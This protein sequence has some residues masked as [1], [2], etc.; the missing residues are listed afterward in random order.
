MTRRQESDA[1]RLSRRQALRI[2]GGLSATAALAACG[3]TPTANPTAGG[4]ATV[5]PATVAA[6]SLA[7]TASIGAASTAP[8]AAGV[9]AT[10]TRGA[11]SATA[12]AASTAITLPPPGA[13]FPTG[14][15][16]VKVTVQGPGPRS[17]F[18][19]EFFAAYK[20]ARPN[21]T[22][23]FDE[24]PAE[25]LNQ[26]VSLSIQNNNAPDI[27][28]LP[29]VVTGGQA[30]QQGWV[31][32][33]DDVIPNFAALK[34]T[35]PSGVLAEGITVFGGKVYTLPL[36]SNQR[37]ETLVIYNPDL[38]QRAGYDPA[39]TPFTWDTFRAACQKITQQGA[40]KY[41]GLILGGKAPD[42]NTDAFVINLAQMAGAA[43]GLIDWRTGLYNYASDQFLA[44]TELLLAISKD[45]SILPGSLSLVQ[46]D[47]TTRLA[48]GGAAMTL[49]GPWAPTRWAEKFNY[50]VASQPVPN[51]GTPLPITYAPGGANLHWLSAKSRNAAIVGDIFGYWSSAPGQTAF[52]GIVGSALQAVLPEARRVAGSDPL[53]QTMSSLF[54]RQ[55]RLAPDPRVRNPDAGQVFVEQRAVRPDLGE[56]LGGLLA[57]QLRD[58]KAAL[59]DLQD[60]S[61]AELD[62]ALKAAQAKGA[63]VSRDDWKFANWDPT[64][65]YTDA[66]Y[67]AL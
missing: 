46:R 56:T 1:I 49:D 38:M 22:V 34:A 2:L 30:V 23:M 33:L 59:K 36:S 44:A 45:G 10:T 13:N 66:D 61:E 60:R 29:T 62:R 39:T 21:V 28:A 58:P 57:G 3:G 63:K 31:A 37:Y 26:A 20:N 25:Q 11:A 54:D 67:K 14:Q 9:A 43:G 42:D 5:A 19:K 17:P 55:M 16:T 6:P 41:Y 52:Q 64:K 47:A 27:F 65:D 51:S 18:Y 53:L 35:F 40:G 4:G 7:T 8:R 48:Q 15:A 24:L 12:S 50:G 32:P